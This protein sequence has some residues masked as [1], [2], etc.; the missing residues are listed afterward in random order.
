MQ[1]FILYLAFSVMETFA[2]FYLAFKAFKIDLYVKEMVFASLIMGTFSFVLRHD[3]GL[4]Q[5]D[6]ILQYLLTVCFLWILFR[7]HV[8]YA[9]IMTG[10]AYQTYLLIQSFLYLVMKFTGLYSDVFSNFIVPTYI[11]QFL[12]A[13][14]IMLLG[15]LVG[16]KRKGFDFVPDKPDGKIAITKREKVLFILNIPSILLS[17]LISY[18]ATNLMHYFIIMPVMYALLLF[19][20]LYLSYK[21]DR[22]LDEFFGQ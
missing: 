13:A 2:L 8:F 3:Y 10:I 20:Y 18:F 15:Y 6:I 14:M 17:P 16:V 7:I 11:L 21:K 19:E 1:E 5:A 4:P 22:V 12:T 9:A